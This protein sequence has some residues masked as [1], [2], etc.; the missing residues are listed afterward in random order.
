MRWRADSDE[1]AE[2]ERVRDWARQHQPTR[3]D[4][5]VQLCE[6][7]GGLTNTGGAQI[8][9]GLD[10]QPLP[11]V[12]GRATMDGPHAVFWVH[13]ALVVSYGHHRGDGSGTVSLV[14]VDRAQPY[15]LGVV[16]QLLWEWT[17]GED[18]VQVAD[19]DLRF[20]VAAVAA[21]RDKARTYHCRSAYYA[22]GR[23]AAGPSGA[24][25]GAGAA[26]GGLPSP[27]KGPGIGYDPV[28]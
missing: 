22:A 28:L 17:D 12:W 23:Y 24:L 16:R 18:P 5:T 2:L 1:V 13:A 3:W 7:G 11:S 4:T 19:T 26:F 15:H 27:L 10:G 21:A 20:P 6:V 14:G 8:V 25:R 9:A